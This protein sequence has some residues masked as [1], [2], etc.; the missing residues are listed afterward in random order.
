MLDAQK[1]AE[2]EGFIKSYN[3]HVSN[4]SE[5]EIREFLSID[6][7]DGDYSHQEQGAHIMACWM[8][9]NDA[10]KPLKQDLVA[11]LTQLKEYSENDLVIT[12]DHTYNIDDKLKELGVG[13][14]VDDSLSTSPG[15]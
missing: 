2:Q 5:S 11:A 6:D 9:W 15:M 3:Q 12:D 10:R 8:L 1:V 4:A 13:V 14:G 7:A